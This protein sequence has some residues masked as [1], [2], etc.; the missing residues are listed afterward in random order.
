MSHPL[1]TATHPLNFRSRLDIPPLPAGQCLTGPNSIRDWLATSG[2]HTQTDGTLFT[3]TA[4]LMA[5]ATPEDRPYPR[6][7][8][9]EEGR[10]LGLALWMPSLQG[11]TIPGQIGELKTILRIKN[12]IEEDLSSRPLAGWKLCDGTTAGLPSLIGAATLNV[13]FTTPSNGAATVAVPSPWFSGTSPD[14]DRYT[15]GYVGA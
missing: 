7:M 14:W 4:G 8:F 9:D 12:T 15:V 2:I 13:T 5:A 6:F 11:W 3:Y 1:L 10:F